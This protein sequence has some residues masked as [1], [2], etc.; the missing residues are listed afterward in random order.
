M[1]KKETVDEI[2]SAAQ[3]E[4]VVSDFVPLKK[5]GQNWVGVCPFHDDKNP[6]M[7]VSPRLGIFNCFVCHTGGNAVNFVMK[8]EQLSYPEALRWLAQKYGIKIVEDE[9]KEELSEEEKLRESLFAINKFAE[10]YFVDQLMNT[11]EG[12]NIGLSYFME[13]GFT[14]QTIEK[15]RLGYCPDGWDNFTQ[16]ALKAGFSLENLILT[17]LTKKSENGK[18]FDFYRGRVI[19]PIFDK[20]GK[21]V[22]FGGRILKKDEKT[23]KYFNSPESPVYHKSNVL[24]G[25]YQAQRAIKSK[26][27]VFL[28]EGYTDVTSLVQAGIENVVATSGTAFPDGQIRLLKAKTNN[29]TVLRDG[30]RA[31]IN[32]ALKDINILLSNNFNVNVVLLPEGED[33]DSFAKSHRDSEIADYLRDNATNFIMFKAKVMADQ[34]GNDP[35]KRAVMVKDIIQS[36]ALIQDD[37]TRQLYVKELAKVFDIEEKILN[38]ELRKYVIKS[39]KEKAE[40]ESTQELNIREENL[41]KEKI[42]QTSFKPQNS[43][44]SIEEIIILQI[45]KYGTFDIDVEI[46]DE[47]NAKKTI[48]KRLDQYIFDELSLENISFQNPMFQRIFEDYAN[49]AALSHS[50]DEIKQFFVN[51]PDEEVKNFCIEKLMIEDTV[52][53]PQWEKRF[54][55]STECVNNCAYKLNQEVECNILMFKHRLIDRYI[56]IL[57]KELE[58]PQTDRIASQILRKLDQLLKRRKEI[59]DMMNLVAT[60]K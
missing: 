48:K 11:E 22:G 36:I 46:T 33:P 50:Q 60:S 15:F 53:S 16:A 56:S 7:Y 20:L 57:Q 32:A 42:S 28:V 26:D 49:V 2:M 34:A 24:Y 30:D 40:K 47:N 25:Y 13:R 27:N 14:M 1:I 23:S 9:Q 6:S 39:F 8:H 55:V 51:H 35:A 29:V 54:E 12:R 17:G 58:E 3:I 10:Q 21:P 18:T 44:Y 43:L 19:F 45:L 59:A 52:V 41:G 38:A 5:R 4:E 31:G 37:I